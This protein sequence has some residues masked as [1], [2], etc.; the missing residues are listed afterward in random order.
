[1]FVPQQKWLLFAQ[2][3]PGARHSPWSGA[4]RAAGPPLRPSVLKLAAWGLA[5]S[6]HSITYFFS[7]GTRNP[8]HKNCESDYHSDLTDEKAECPECGDLQRQ[9][10]KA[11]IPHPLSPTPAASQG[12]VETSPGRERECL[13]VSRG[14]RRRRSELPSITYGGPVVSGA[15][16]HSL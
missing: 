1:M 2:H 14:V 11:C 10:V 8:S 13:G 7:T 15:F 16:T 3:L 5:Q 9:R 12:E 6:R 4:A